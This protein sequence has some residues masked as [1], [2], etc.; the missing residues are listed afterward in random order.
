MTFKVTV[1]GTGSARP[2]V[3]RRHSAQVLN[4]HEQFYLVD[5]GEGT[6]I[7]LLE[8]G[9][10]LLRLN[11][12]FISHLHGDHVYGLFPLISS[13]GI[14]GRKTPFTVFAPAP[15]GEVIACHYRY[16]DTN[17]PFEVIYREVDTRSNE[18]IYENN[19]MQVWSI[20]LRHRVPASGYLFREKTPPLNVRKDAIERFGLGIAQITAAKRGEDIVSDD[21]ALIAS[22]AEITYTPYSPR[23][24]AY[25]SDT[26]SSG[27]VAS[28]VSGVDLLY[29]EAT[30]ADEDRALAKETGHSTAS[31]AA[32]IAQQAGAGKLLIGHF[33]SRYK[34]D[35][36]LLD[37][38]R[39]IFTDTEL[40][41]EKTTYEIPVVKNA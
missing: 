7:R 1:L 22:N 34:D 9:I 27:K 18:M 39:A 32:R 33:S 6:Q 2:T 10:P 4:I 24:Y 15:F 20:P 16:F 12:A 36:L 31:Q 14:M 11:A 23:S 17:L 26:Q 29:H 30:F 38:A 41:E 3:S 8:C 5:C 40:A 37:E 35:T 21:G 25:C 19:V 13:M 28:I